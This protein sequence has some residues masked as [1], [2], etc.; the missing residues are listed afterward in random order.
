MLTLVIAAAGEIY[1][2]S[3]I[4]SMV[5]DAIKYEIEEVK[6]IVEQVREK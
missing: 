4:G 2:G 3:K 1:L 6:N 5:A